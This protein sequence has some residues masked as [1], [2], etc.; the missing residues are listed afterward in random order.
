MKE[1]EITGECGTNTEKKF[2]KQMCGTEWAAVW[3]SIFTGNSRRGKIVTIG[4]T[5]IHSLALM[6]CVCVCTRVRVIGWGG[7]GQIVCNTVDD[8]M[9]QHSGQKDDQKMRR[10]KKE[11][12]KRT[13]NECGGEMCRFHVQTDLDRIV[14]IFVYKLVTRKESGIK[15]YSY[16]F[17]LKMQRMCFCFPA[18]F[19]GFDVD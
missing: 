4:L 3:Q 18:K 16:L 10:C 2:I 9:N 19:V 5:K 1:K 12:K 6:V 13:N 11:E 14:S 8:K 7:R 17:L 15:S